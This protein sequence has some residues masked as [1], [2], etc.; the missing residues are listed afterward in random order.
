M[1]GVTFL[2]TA[3]KTLSMFWGWAMENNSWKYD[4]AMWEICSWEVHHLSSK[5]NTPD[6]WFFLRRWLARLWK[7]FVF[8]SPTGSQIDQDLCR[9]KSSSWWI[10]FVILA[11][12]LLMDLTFS[13]L[14]CKH[15]SSK[16]FLFFLQLWFWESKGKSTPINKSKMTSFYLFKQP[17]HWASI[18]YN[19]VPSH[20][21]D[22]F[23]VR[24][25]GPS[26]LKSVWYLL[27]QGGVRPNVG[28]D[29]NWAVVRIRCLKVSD[30]HLS[31]F[32]PPFNRGACPI[33]SFLH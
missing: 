23:I 22:I 17:R 13:V 9:Q 24:V 7:Y 2:W 10:M 27:P 21:Y 11:L 8:L 1:C 20:L 31:K 30:L 4:S 16:I 14:F 6:I 3:C 32:I 28:S 19:W 33:Q 5:S 29:K 18:R 25:S 15:N 26:L 12:R